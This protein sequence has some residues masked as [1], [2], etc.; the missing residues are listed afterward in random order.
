MGFAHH[1]DSADLCATD[2]KEVTYASTTK[3]VLSHQENGC[4]HYRYSYMIVERRTILLWPK[5]TGG[6]NLFKK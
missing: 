4:V 6:Q 5:I 2:I 1:E 3:F